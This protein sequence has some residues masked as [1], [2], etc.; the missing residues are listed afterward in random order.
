MKKLNAFTLIEIIMTM[1]LSVVVFSLIFWAYSIS[2]KNYVQYNEFNS[3]LLSLSELDY[4]L[5]QDFFKAKEVRLIPKG[6]KID[7]KD[8]NDIEYNFEEE[9]IIRKQSEKIDSFLFTNQ[10]LAFFLNDNLSGNIDGL[11]DQLTFEINKGEKTFPF[12]FK[13]H[14]DQTTLFENK[15]RNNG[16]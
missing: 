7:F 9:F 13:K 6:I 10:N 5:E 12:S 3:K 2:I 1:L 15:I 11:I 14:Y 4:I 8:A 16:R